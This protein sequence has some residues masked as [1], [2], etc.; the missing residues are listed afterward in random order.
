MLAAGVWE[1]TKRASG[2]HDAPCEWEFYVIC[3]MG[4][5][6]F[7]LGP[8]CSSSLLAWPGAS[9]RHAG[10]QQAVY[11]SLG[12]SPADAAPVKTPPPPP[13]KTTTKLPSPSAG[14]P[15]PPAAAA[16]VPVASPSR[17]PPPL[18]A[19]RSPPA[20]LNPPVVTADHNTAGSSSSST[21]GVVVGVAAA[22]GGLAAI[23]VAAGEKCAAAC[24]RVHHFFCCNSHWAGACLD[25]IDR[26]LPPLLA[27][28]VWGWKRHAQASQ[29]A[30][31]AIAPAGMFGASAA[32][33]AAPPASTGIS[34]GGDI[35]PKGAALSV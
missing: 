29:Q 26:V 9:L 31:V 3:Q 8:H 34:T 28:A 21:S 32:A 5:F 11:P 16:T 17:V 22:A 2:W 1:G 25:L 10:M 12:P 18:A 33:A 27:A 13:P 19:V 6:C 30:H 14:A 7:A 24:H 23:A 20:V 4:G 35:M 15:P